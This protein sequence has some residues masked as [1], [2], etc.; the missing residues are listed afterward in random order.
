VFFV[1]S[2]G[3]TALAAP[4]ANS[5][6]HIRSPNRASLIIARLVRVI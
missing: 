2:R 3:L 4:N 6:A 5:T 1:R